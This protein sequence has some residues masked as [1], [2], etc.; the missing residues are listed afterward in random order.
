MS[1]DMKNRGSITDKE[2]IATLVDMWRTAK[3]NR[4]ER[5]NE[6][7]IN[8]LTFKKSNKLFVMDS[9][10]CVTELPYEKL[11][12][13]T[14]MRVNRVFP[15]ARKMISQIHANRPLFMPDL[16]TYEGQKEFDA[17]V[18]QALAVTEYERWEEQGII[19]E[20]ATYFTTTGCYIL[21]QFYNKN[22]GDMIQLGETRVRIGE[23][24]V[25]IVPIF[26][27][28]FD[29]SV[30]RVQN[31]QWATQRIV[32]PKDL[33][34]EIFKRKLTTFNIDND[35]VF[36]YTKN[37]YYKKGDY[38]TIFE[39]YKKPSDE[40]EKGY[41][42]QFT[43]NEILDE[44]DN[45]TP[46]AALPYTMAGAVNMADVYSESP[47]TYARPLMKEYNLRR[48]QLGDHAK[49]F[50]KPMLAIDKTSNLKEEKFGSDRVSVI[51]TN[52][53]TG[54]P[55]GYVQPAEFSQYYHLNMSLIKEEMSDI[56]G[57]HDISMGKKIGTRTPAMSMAIMKEQDDSMNAPI[58]KN[59]YKGIEKALNMHLDFVREKYREKRK[60]RYFDKENYLYS[61]YIGTR[62]QKGLKVKLVAVFGLSDNKIVRQ[63]QVERLL[64]LGM[65]SKDKATE[66]LE[67]GELEKAY[68]ITMLDK[69][70]ASMENDNMA[71]GKE[72]VV[73]VYE[74]HIVH[75]KKHLERLRKADFFISPDLKQEE[76]QEIIGKRVV[77]Y[78]HLEAH[79]QAVGFLTSQNIYQASVIM[80][81]ESMSQLEMNLFFKT[82]SQ[83]EQQRIAKMQAA[84]Q[85]GGQ[86]PAMPGFNSEQDIMNAA[87]GI[88]GMPPQTGQLQ[89]LQSLAMGNIVN[90]I[91][92]GGAF[93]GAGGGEEE[94]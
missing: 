4:R 59:F 13:L 52:L 25:D 17:R 78:K 92:G 14:E 85:G 21:K 77:F 41:F 16:K 91:A 54:V 71:D 11:N 32:L 26:D 45:P 9:D 80:G 24:D 67:F 40:N 90:E 61:D 47:I 50:G 70:R 15:V 68:S 8:L 86:P 36:D 31:S 10:G 53:K 1:V 29:D 66:F 51:R 33:A 39:H 27:V 48:H 83:M 20:L 69:I 72:Q 28:V 22:K 76:I 89:Q 30:S 73:D 46:N 12:K 42:C 44:G 37:A 7:L 43:S 84:Q 5:E 74:N 35:T 56:V 49:K 87:Q 93:Q 3:D 6:W 88:G 23:I 58:V 65:I 19:D 75:I 94:V 81:V 57:V 63:Q 79:W 18:Q 64:A 82:I 2:K 34:E 55:P 60:I 62:L 38:V